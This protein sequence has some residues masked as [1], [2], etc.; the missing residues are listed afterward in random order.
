M[1]LDATPVHRVRIGPTKVLVEQGLFPRGIHEV[2]PSNDV[3]NALQVI[4][5]RALKV[6][7]RP[8]L[9]L[10]S[11]LW[12]RVRIG[13]GV[14]QAQRRP[15]TECR[16]ALVHAGFHANDRFSRLVCATEHA[17]PS[18]AVLIRGFPPAGAFG[19]R[20]AELAEGFR[21]AGANVAETL[22]DHG[23]GVFM[24]H[25][26]AIAGDDHA[27]GRSAEQPFRFLLNGV[28]GLGHGRLHDGVCVVKPQDEGSLV[29]FCIGSVDDQATSV[30][31]RQ[32]PVRVGCK[33]EDNLPFNRVFQVWESDAPFRFGACFKQFRGHR[34]QFLLC[35][36]Q[37]LLGHESIRFR[38]CGSH[39]GG[40]LTAMRPKVG[41]HAH[42]AANDGT[43]HG[44]SVVFDGVLQRDEAQKRQSVLVRRPCHAAQYGLQG[45]LHEDGGSNNR[46]CTEVPDEVRTGIGTPWCT[47]QAR[48]WWPTTIARRG[49][50][51]P[52]RAAQGVPAS[53][54]GRSGS[55]N[56]C[57][58]LCGQ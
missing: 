1:H 35:R 23:G 21:T 11:D 40:E 14:L 16:V 42:D 27:V 53:I 3:C 25:V 30:S 10:G 31:K 43:S 51:G 29:P 37:A 36:L 18:G 47:D 41:A 20:D 5:N 39:C 34:R 19:L 32:G 46:R 26:D 44:F 15:V 57:Q 24:V 45:A 38:D 2:L 33:P 54:S 7:K 22:L 48:L 55:L 17:L 58:F 52:L 6:E 56:Q 28:V 13:H 4:L 9:V 12:P 49:A 8:Y 50:V